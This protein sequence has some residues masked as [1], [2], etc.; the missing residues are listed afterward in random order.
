MYFGIERHIDNRLGPTSGSPAL[1]VSFDSHEGAHGYQHDRGG[2]KGDEEKF[3]CKR[4][5]GSDSR[6][7]HE[8]QQG[9]E[10]DMNLVE[11]YISFSSSNDHGEKDDLLDSNITNIREG[12]DRQSQS[13]IPFLTLQ[14]L[15]FS[16]QYISYF[17][18]IDL[19]SSEFGDIVY[20][21][22]R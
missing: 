22:I 2:A 20:E 21:G 11:S 12:D 18:F 9:Q 10:H 14:I 5:A 19:M 16:C 4:G 3:L 6:V 8:I 13:F 1:F 7:T 15:W 17:T